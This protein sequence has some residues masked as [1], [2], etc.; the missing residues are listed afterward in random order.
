MKGISKG[1]SKAAASGSSM[2]ACDPCAEQA[3]K[4][5]R[6]MQ[7]QT[8]AEWQHPGKTGEAFPPRALVAFGGGEQGNCVTGLERGVLGAAMRE[9]FRTEVS[10]TTAGCTME[11]RAL[12]DGAFQRHGGNDVMGC[13]GRGRHDSGTNASCPGSRGEGVVCAEKRHAG[14]NLASTRGEGKIKRKC[15]MKDD[16]V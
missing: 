5:T 12:R 7:V 3:P 14:S 9:K 1:C 2:P 15:E 6:Y 16:T 10:G 8:R 4:R 11:G 13:R